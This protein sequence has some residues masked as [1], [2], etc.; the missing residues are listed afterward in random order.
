MNALSGS[1]PVLLSPELLPAES[2]EAL[3]LS[4]AA[5]ARAGEALRREIALGRLPGA[6]ALIARHGRI[7][8]F[9]AFGR[10]GPDGDA[11]MTRDAI[12]RIYSMTKPVVSLAVLM[13]LEEGRLLLDEPL[14]QYL[15]EFAGLKVGHPDPSTP[16]GLRLVPPARPVSLHDLLRHTS[17][18]TYEFLGDGPVHRAYQRARLGDPR[19]SN[20]E[21][22]ETLA[23]LPLIAEPG[24][25]WGY[26]RST[27]VLGR[28]IEVVSGVSLGEFLRRQIFE[29]LGMH[30]TAFHVEAD[31]HHR[32][33]EPFPVD[34]DTGEVVRL[35][36]PRRRS[37]LEMGGGGLM[38]T[39]ADYLRFA[40]MLADGGKAGGRRL[41]SRKTIEL[42]T[43]DHLGVVPSDLDLLSPGHG[44]GLGVAVRTAA[45]VASGPG[46]PGQYFWSGIAG[47][48]FWV[49]PVE[50]MVA[51]FLAQAPGRR[52]HL[53]QL[54]RALAYAAIDD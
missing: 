31:Q 5:L 8:W 29:P 43:A 23:E 50:R 16:D 18:M 42:M 1:P 34:P 4:S 11:P 45:G 32:I 38:S 30:D 52:A 39:A 17:G 41:V 22:C 19:R 20:A 24:E 46:S 12:F 54:F 33:A 21:L 10:L 36:D 3:G 49:D 40:Q 51:I 6:V 27:D 47:T 37:A 53:R 44:F 2:P 14:A 9:E 13:L 25:R 26:G 35:L 28:V 15:P 48:T 7:G